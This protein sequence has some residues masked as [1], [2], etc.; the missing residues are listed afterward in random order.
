MGADVWVQ[1]TL[2][3]RLLLAPS[4][5]GAWCVALCDVLGWPGGWLVDLGTCS[6]VQMG[7]GSGAQL[8]CLLARPGLT[9]PVPQTMDPI[10]KNASAYEEAFNRHQ[11]L[12]TS[13]FAS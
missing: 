12:G 5:C 1:E 11:E 8:P 3:G 9:E 4:L 6:R 10:A 2:R 13:L 7:M